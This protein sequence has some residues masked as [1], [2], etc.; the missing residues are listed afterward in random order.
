MKIIVFAAVAAVLSGP[1]GAQERKPVPK[2]SARVFVS[3]C[4]KGY[5]FTA[6]P[7]TEDQP[8]VAIPLGM[9]LRMSGPKALIAEIKGQE[10]SRIEL[11]GLVKRGQIAQDGVAV[12][13]G[14]RVSGAAPPSGGGMRPSPGTSPVM[15][16]VEGWRRVLGDCPS[17]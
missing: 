5:V 3:G 6:G 7:R 17:H 2:D 15:I 12:G 4:S 1:L 14:V 16:D 9:H 11:T 13:G 10:G 8:G